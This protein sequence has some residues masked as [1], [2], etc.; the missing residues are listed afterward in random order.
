MKKTYWKLFVAAL[1]AVMLT[2]CQSG[3]A[4]TTPVDPSEITPPPAVAAPAEDTEESS[5]AEVITDKED[6]KPFVAG[7]SFS[8][9]K[10]PAVDSDARYL[11][12]EAVDPPQNGKI[13]YS[14]N[15]KTAGKV[16]GTAVQNAGNASAEVRAVPELGYKFIEWSDGVKDAS[17]S[18]DI[19]EGV[20]TAIFDYDV[21]DMPIVVINTDD[22]DAITSK[23]VYE[24]AKISFLGCD[25]K[26]LIEEAATE[27]RGR[28]NNSWGYPKKS[29][30]FKLAEKK[31]LF[32]LANG[33]EKIW[34]LLANQCDQ[35][36]QRNHVSFEYARYFDAVEWQP[37]STS[38]EVY[39]NG[40]YVGVYLLAEEIKISGDRVNVDERDI[41]KVDTGYLLELSNYASG[42][43]INAAGR[44]YMI[45]NDL[46]ADRTTMKEQKKFIEDYVD[47]CYEALSGGSREKCEELIDLDSLAAVYLVEEMVKNLDSQWDSF[48]L[49]KDAGGKLVFGP[50]W[51][52][53]LSL[54]NANEGAEEYTD[55]FVGNG[56]GS[57]GGFGTW[58]AV[59]LV[60]DW[61]RE[62]VAE[63]WAEI[64]D[65]VS[66]MPQYILDEGKLGLRSYERNFEKWQIFG[67]TQNRE[68]HYITRLKNYTEHYEYLAEWLSNR[69]EWLNGVFTDEAFVKEGKEILMVQWM[70][71]GGGFWGAH[72]GDGNNTS[73]YGNDAAEEIAESYDNLMDMYYKNGSADGPDGN[74]GEGVRNLFDGDKNTKYCLDV[75]GEIEVTFELKRAQA[76]KAYMFRTGNDTR[77]Y[78]S[79]NPNSWA[80]YGRSKTSDEWTLIQEV[81]D[82]EAQLGPTNQLW[83]GFEVENPTAYKY[84]KFVFRENGLIQLSEIR[85][86]GDT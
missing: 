63:K 8:G 4:G 82:G 84:Y 39:L 19:A 52:F 15:S 58:F 74:P 54:G 26:Y 55:I 25:R 17:R 56:R 47:E 34:V 67:T 46:S 3:D 77:D 6:P 16:E 57:G 12:T 11:T 53:D 33:K 31:N 86:L 1:A 78:S 81:A 69:L 38:V 22:G 9:T 36:L 59:A 66:L 37:N 80:F 28:G 71:Q 13:I 72:A 51:D 42:E 5:S 35:S 64:Y 79:R 60:Q 41:N 68:T 45:H 76:V 62:M 43:V 21:L 2:A 32:D 73:R 10:R 18:G 44:T 75:P 61:F 40:E 50:V 30:K 49:H 85:L 27:I 24:T 7:T 83:Y 23:T 29:F 48:Y 70:N 65:S 14:V 20:Y